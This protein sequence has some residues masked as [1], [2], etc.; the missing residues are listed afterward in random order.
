MLLVEVAEQI[1]R[2]IVAALSVLLPVAIFVT[3][4]VTANDDSTTAN[5]NGVAFAR[6][7]APK[8]Q[9]QPPNYEPPTGPD[10]TTVP[11]TTTAPVEPSPAEPAPGEPAPTV[12]APSTTTPPSQP[13]QDTN[14]SPDER[15][16]A[17]LALVEFPW[18]QRLPGW[19]ISFHPERSGVYGY[20]LVT[21]RRIEVY[22]RS[23]QT[24]QLLAHVVAH[25]IGHAIDVTHNDGADR[26]RWVK[27]RGLGQAPWWPADGAADF[28]TGAGDFAESFAAWQVGSESFR[29]KLGPAPSS[30]QQTL[31]RQLALD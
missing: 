25:E 8:Q 27:A 9:D 14:R 2:R 4:G 5:D 6:S 29:S 12:V 16:Q 13:V 24:D 26:D 17:A 21:E 18:A 31:L 22:V 1:S 30:E 28:S 10:L 3:V 7:E 11:P 20:T 19:K 23:D 15:G